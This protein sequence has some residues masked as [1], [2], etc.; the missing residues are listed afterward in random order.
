MISPTTATQR[1]VWTAFEAM[2]SRLGAKIDHRYINPDQVIPGVTG[3]PVFTKAIDGGFIR[4]H[5][6]NNDG[7][8]FEVA[9]CFPG[10][11]YISTVN[12]FGMDCQGYLHAIHHLTESVIKGANNLKPEPIKSKG[13][14]RASEKVQI[15]PTVT[16]KTRDILAKFASERG[17]KMSQAVELLA[18]ECL[19]GHIDD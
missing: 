18:R 17:L 15:Q 3:Y 7:D 13:Y 11:H 2:M 1:Q 4:L 14:R 12:S 19:A 16:T 6:E 5:L 9:I 8:T 10:K